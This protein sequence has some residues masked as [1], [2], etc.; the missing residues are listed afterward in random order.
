METEK[1][2]K[3]PASIRKKMQS[4]AKH[5]AAGGDLMAQVDEWFIDRGFDIDQLRSG[6]GISL[7]EIEYGIDISDKICFAIEHNGYGRRP[8]TGNLIAST[9]S[10]V[11]E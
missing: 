3:V 7:E 9:L 4:A 8:E 2:I 1:L 10:G 11:N 5:F 6:D